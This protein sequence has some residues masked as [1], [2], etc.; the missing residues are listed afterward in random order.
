MRKIKNPK[1]YWKALAWKAFSVMIR[2]SK[3]NHHGFGVCVTCPPKK[4]IKPWRELQ[5]GHFVAGRGNSVL[6]DERLV[7]PQCLTAE[8]KVRLFNGDYKN[9]SKLKKGD[10]LWAFDK[11]T[12]LKS[13]S[14]VEKVNSFV[15]ED[16]YQ[17][18]MEDGSI[19]FATGDHEVVSNKKWIKVKDMLHN[20]SAHDI[21]KI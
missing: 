8:S 3:A 9:I 7:H 1:K 2:K 11:D 10:K 17:V 21:L 20:L 18:E 6:F 5:A 12:F 13:I 4:A 14:F 15:P 19:F 16:L